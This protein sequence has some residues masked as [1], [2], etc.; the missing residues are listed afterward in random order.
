LPAK[1]PD[2]DM[3]QPMRNG[4]P[5]GAALCCATAGMATVAAAAPA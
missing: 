5:D 1:P 3:E 2:S 4:G